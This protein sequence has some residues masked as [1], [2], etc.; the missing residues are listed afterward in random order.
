MSIHYGGNARQPAKGSPIKRQMPRQRKSNPVLRS[1]RKRE[2]ESEGG[3][4]VEVERKT[5][6]A[7]LM[8]ATHKVAC[9][10]CL[11]KIDN[12]L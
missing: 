9:Q 3:R 5:T 11:I 8:K 2:R 7:F 10:V 4:E 12:I 1:N 6:L